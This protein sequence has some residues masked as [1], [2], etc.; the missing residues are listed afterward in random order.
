MNFSDS[1]FFEQFKKMPIK[2][3]IWDAYACLLASSFSKCNT[4]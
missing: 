1:C 3:K 2:N 4:I